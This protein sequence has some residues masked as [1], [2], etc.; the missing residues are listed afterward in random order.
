MP[1]GAGSRPTDA[2]G[3]ALYDEVEEQCVTKGSK[4]DHY[5]MHIT[6]QYVE[7]V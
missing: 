4:E 2:D 6:P 7:W 3:M 5:V 1:K